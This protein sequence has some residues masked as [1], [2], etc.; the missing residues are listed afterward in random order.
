M[1]ISHRSHSLT[2]LDGFW[3]ETFLSTH[4]VPYFRKFVDR[5]VI[6]H[7]TSCPK[8]ELTCGG[9]GGVTREPRSSSVPFVRPRVF[10][11]RYRGS[12]LRKVPQRTGEV[13]TFGPPTRMFIFSRSFCHLVVP[14]PISGF[15]L[16]FYHDP[17]DGRSSVQDYSSSCVSE[18]HT[19][20]TDTGTWG[21]PVSRTS[22]RLLT[23]LLPPPHLSRRVPFPLDPLP[24][25]HKASQWSFLSRSTS[26]PDP[27]GP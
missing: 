18:F 25:I 6:V 22:Y 1:C 16:K 24:V 23:F 15:T 12:R 3:N 5:N 14:S 26:C 13:N 19:E 7:P 4:L 9:K 20:S 27:S 10:T 17:N 8:A 11:S 21:L 2:P